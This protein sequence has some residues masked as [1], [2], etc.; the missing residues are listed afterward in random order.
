MLPNPGQIIE[1]DFELFDWNECISCFQKSIDRSGDFG[2]KPLFDG[3]KIPSFSVHN[4]NIIPQVQKVKDFILSMTRQKSC[5][6]HMF[7]S[8]TNES[9]AWN[10][11]SDKID[12]Y[13]WQVFGKTKWNVDFYDLECEL[14]PN[15]MIYIPAGTMHKATPIEPRIA[16]SFGISEEDE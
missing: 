10:W 9:H 16:L 3:Q 7:V 13:V 1:Y 4:A 12:V 8:L 6:S 5:S 2:V 11:H 14:A 15:Q